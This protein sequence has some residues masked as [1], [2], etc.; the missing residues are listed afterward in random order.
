MRF[1]SSWIN[2]DANNEV[3]LVKENS[4]GGTPV[5]P[6]RKSWKHLLLKKMTCKICFK[7]QEDDD[8]HSSPLRSSPTQFSFSP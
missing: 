2:F 6:K 1:N 5:L 8:A 3:G 4:L 7:N